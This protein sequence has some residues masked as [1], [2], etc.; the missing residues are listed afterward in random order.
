MVS[1]ATRETKIFETAFFSDNK[2]IKVQWTNYSTVCWKVKWSVWLRILLAKRHSS[3]MEITIE[4]P[5]CVT[6][7]GTELVVL[8]V[9]LLALCD[10][11]RYFMWGSLKGN[12]RTVHTR[13]SAREG[14]LKSSRQNGRHSLD[15][16]SKSFQQ[17]L[18]QTSCIPERWN[19]S[20]TP[21]QTCS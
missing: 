14:D 17:F 7:L 8:G 13:A 10:C 9:C 4:R 6:F 1:C 11:M 3:S 2:V 5:P 18:F 20:S 19:L 12:H 16:N 15:R 21:A